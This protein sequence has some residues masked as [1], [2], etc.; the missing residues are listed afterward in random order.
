[1]ARVAIDHRLK[2]LHVIPSISPLRGGPS[3]M[4]RTMVRGL[5]RAGVE[6]DAATTDDDGPGR[7]PVS[8]KTP[9]VESGV[10]YWYFPRQTRFYIFSWPLSHWLA[11]HV[12]D[13]DLVHIHAIFSYASIPA[14]F[15]A[16][17]YRVPYI[18]RPLG[19]LNR[20]GMQNR[21]PWLKQLSFR[22]IEQHILAGAAAIH[23]T[24]KQE[25]IEAEELGVTNRAVVIPNA[26]DD[27]LLV[28]SF[29]TG[30]FR[31]H[32]PQFA[33]R[34]IIL[35][36]S[37]VDQKKGLDI[38]LPAFAQVK[39]RFPEVR[40]VIAGNG[41]VDFIGQLQQ[42]A[43]RLKIDK[44]VL[45]TGFLSGEEKRYALA[46]ADIFALPSYSENFGIAVVEAMACGLPVVI[47]DQ[48]GIHHEVA[49]AQAGIVT[50]CEI[51]EIAH[52]LSLFTS[53]AKQR[54]RMGENGRR[55][56]R[57]HC[58]S[59]TVTEKLIAL[60][61]QVIRSSCEDQLSRTVCGS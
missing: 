28:S 24:S 5:V 15:Y 18:V 13:Y 38:L 61:Q 19:V 1:M 4:L 29:P 59:K 42:E 3:V 44:G 35:F 60:Y 40:L 45:W 37:R 25:Q 22:F 8:H 9:V 34:V 58:S 33:D 57:Q 48:V 39:E 2:V 7:I 6:V 43:K 30:R 12:Q 21:H 23:Y 52:A 16:K 51:N 46:D 31:A 54:S 55:W 10:T 14:A 49:T 36:L 32:Y 56:V 11:Q 41:D 26:V 53:D 17:R 20:W 50:K 27:V 47:S